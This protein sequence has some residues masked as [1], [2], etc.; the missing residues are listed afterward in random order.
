MDEYLG[1]NRANWDARASAHVRSPDYAVGRFIEDPMFISGV[2]RF[3]LDRLGDIAGLTGVHLQCHIGTATVSLARLG[4]QMTGLDF[5]PRSLREAKRV[6]EQAHTPVR[7]VEAD[8]Y[9]AL[10]VLDP[11]SF[12]LVYTGIGALCWLPDI[13][14]WARTVAGLLRP[15]GRLFVREMHPMLATID[16][17]HADLIVVDYPYFE[18]VEPMVFDDGGTYVETDVEFAATQTYEWSHGLGQTVSALLDSGMQLTDLVEHDSVPWQALPGHMSQDE[19][20]E[21]RLTARPW[22]LAAS[23]TLQARRL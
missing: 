14:R 17:S 20:G 12:D 18:R 2:V 1:V 5:S 19:F 10:D 16:D 21:W 6:A 11:E 15:G 22:R 8:V 23:F 13:A 9:S 4:A 3:D 7:F